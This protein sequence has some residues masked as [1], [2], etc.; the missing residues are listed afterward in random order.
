M[1]SKYILPFCSLPFN[2]LNNVFWKENF[3]ILMKFILSIFFFYWFM[4]VVSFTSSFFNLDLIGINFFICLLVIVF[5]LCES[6]S[7][8]LCLIFFYCMHIFVMIY[9]GSLYIKDFHYTWY[10]Y[11]SN[12]LCIHLLNN[13]WATYYVP[14]TLLDTEKSSVNKIK[15]KN[16]VLKNYNFVWWRD[17]N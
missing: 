15:S 2:F 7:S 11:L 10:K 4:F 14:D 8:C 16:H 1:F 17:V 5:L 9:T 13:S 6:L 12:S 3:L